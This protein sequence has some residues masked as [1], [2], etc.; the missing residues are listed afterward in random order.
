MAITTHGGTTDAADKTGGVVPIVSSAGLG[1][2][3]PIKEIVRKYA[4]MMP[5]QSNYEASYEWHVKVENVITRAC[6][7]YA[8]SLRV[9]QYDRELRLA[10]D[11]I[12]KWKA[13]ARRLHMALGCRKNEKIRVCAELG[14]SKALAPNK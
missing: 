7:E 10:E 9:P 3:S 1:A 2:D 6:Y 14:Y 5:A 8:E 4:N 12:E 13:V 11:E